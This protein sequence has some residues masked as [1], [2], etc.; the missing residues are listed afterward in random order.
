[1]NKTEHPLATVHGM[2]LHLVVRS[3][4]KT[5]RVFSNAQKKD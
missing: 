2:A 1:M 4:R 3:V 5:I